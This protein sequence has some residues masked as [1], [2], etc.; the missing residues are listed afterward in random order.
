MK[1]KQLTAEGKKQKKKQ[2]TAGIFLLAAN[3]V[4][5][6]TIWLMNSYDEIC[7]DQFLYQLK[8]STVGVDHSLT[9]SAVLVV[10]VS[11]FGSC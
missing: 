2:I 3:I 6:L 11:S 10:G 7:I 8:S 5:F 1:D 4:F 9:E